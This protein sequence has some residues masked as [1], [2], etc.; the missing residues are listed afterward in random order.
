MVQTH[1]R[2]RFTFAMKSA[3]VAASAIALVALLIQLRHLV[4]AA[5][6]TVLSGQRGVTPSYVEKRLG[7]PNVA[8]QVVAHDTSDFN[9]VYSLDADGFRKTADPWDSPIIG[10]IVFLGCSFTFGIGVADEEVYPSLIAKKF[11]RYRIINQGLSACGTTHAMLILSDDL[12]RRRNLKAVVYGYSNLH[13]CRNHRRKEWQSMPERT[14]FHW[15]ELEEGHPV[16]RGSFNPNTIEL[17]PYSTDLDK[18]EHNL[19][20]ALVLEMKHQCDNAGVPF[21]LLVIGASPKYD[22]PSDTFVMDAALRGGVNV[23]DVR[24]VSGYFAEDPHPTKEW[25]RVVAERVCDYLE[26]NVAKSS[27]LRG[28]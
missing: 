28:G 8:N 3:C 25:H 14:P 5:H 17:L 21:L 24:D 23:L 7:I 11:G 27:R 12:S 16:Y 19:T 15:F 20:A 2:R 4:N 1:S 26:K 18:A 13:L 9:V 10:E 22:T 6:I